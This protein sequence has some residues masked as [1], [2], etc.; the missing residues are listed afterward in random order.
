MYP[1]FKIGKLIEQLGVVVFFGYLV[2]NYF[3]K[4]YDIVF[5]IM[6]S[7]AALYLAGGVIEKIG[8]N[9]SS[10]LPVD[11]SEPEQE[12]FITKYPKRSFFINFAVTVA[13]FVGV[14]FIRV[15][16]P[17]KNDPALVLPITIF[18]IVFGTLLLCLIHRMAKAKKNKKNG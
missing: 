13:I 10:E 9:K 7:G 6:F 11:S 16:G 18:G 14:F 12:S 3:T 1:L 17:L 8:K 2:A 5:P 15:Y 4:S